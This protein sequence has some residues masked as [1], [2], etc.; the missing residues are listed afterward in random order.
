M[1]VQSVEQKEPWT[2]VGWVYWKV[3]MKA[4]YL[5]YPKA[6]MKAAR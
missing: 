6:V 3:A 4:E 2:P 5:G 1:V